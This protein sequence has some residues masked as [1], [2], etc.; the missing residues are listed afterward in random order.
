ME[1]F[2]S[3]KDSGE[4]LIRTSQ[5]IYVGKGDG[6]DFDIQYLDEKQIEEEEDIAI[7][8]V[9]GELENLVD[10]YSIDTVS[11]IAKTI[12]KVVNSEK[13]KHMLAP[14]WFNDEATIKSVAKL[15]RNNFG[16]DDA[17][18][19]AEIKRMYWG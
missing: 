1:K 12:Q 16:Y 9:L 2:T 15:I 10:N 5:A 13:V 3:G 14:D 7:K 6:K 4:K 11:P 18:V 19:E 8:S 17:R